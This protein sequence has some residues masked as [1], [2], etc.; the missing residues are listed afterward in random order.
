MTS[1]TQQILSKNTSL[2]FLVIGKIALF[3]I[4]KVNCVSGLSEKECCRY[5][6]GHKLYAHVIF[7]T[8]LLFYILWD[9][10]NLNVLN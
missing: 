6:A 10:I 2:S 1:S 3:G 7:K 8:N 5:F 4:I 9:L